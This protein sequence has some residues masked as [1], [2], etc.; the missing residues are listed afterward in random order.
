M[1]LQDYQEF[2]KLLTDIPLPF[3]KLSDSEISEIFGKNGYSKLISSK[4]TS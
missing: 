3:T 4:K 1:S 2:N